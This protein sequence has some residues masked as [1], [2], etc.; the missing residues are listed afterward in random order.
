MNRFSFW[1]KWLLAL[2]VGIAILGVVLA[3]WGGT[4]LFDWL[5]NLIDPT[6]W[7]TQSPGVEANA[8]RQWVYAVLGAV[9]A[10]WGLFL[11]FIAR[12]PFARQERW[13]WN[14]TISGLLL[15][16]LID[17]SASL[18]FRVYVNAIGNTGLLVLALLPLIF[19]RKQ[20][21]H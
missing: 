20:F 2:S 8:F 9:M 4:P 14:C 21:A 10:S 13:A 16:F 17:T 1:Q 7:G 18:Y 3:L 15:W 5:N 19:T 11:V 12:Y 6:F